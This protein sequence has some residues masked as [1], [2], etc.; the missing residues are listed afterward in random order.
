MRINKITLE[1]F[2]QY[3]KETIAFPEG[4]IGLIGKNGAGK[5]T[6]FEAVSLALYGKCEMP[7]DKIK[8][9]KA[10]P[11]EA[12]LVELEFEDRDKCL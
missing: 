4:L 1:N 10:S 2:K 6:V 3:K 8:N 7:K 5:S 9:D 12:V 11:K